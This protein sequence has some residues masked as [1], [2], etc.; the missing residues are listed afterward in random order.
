MRRRKPKLLRAVRPNAGLIARY[1]RRL[2]EIV[3]RMADGVERSILAAWRADPPLA[4]DALPTAGL[5]SRVDEM[6]RKWM[7]DFDALAEKLADYF[8]TAVKDR[9]D[10]TLKSALADS[11]LAVEFKMTR[12]M[13]DVFRATVQANVA[14]IKSIPQHYLAEVEGSVMRAA[15]AGRD[16]AQLY[17]DLRQYRG[18]T[19]RRAAFISLD[20]MNKATSALT[21]ARQQEIGITQGVWRHSHAGKTPRP[22][23][24]AQDGKKFSLKEGWYDPAVK[25]RIWPGTEPRCRCFWTPVLPGL[26]E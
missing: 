5:Q 15:Q 14:L 26:G 16:E 13:R 9:S 12:A 24:V 4:S 3:G 21:S 20:Q 10:A 8:V 6:R 1:R 11:G 19:K 7:A 2:D 18:V 25:K 23:H 22:T 17:R